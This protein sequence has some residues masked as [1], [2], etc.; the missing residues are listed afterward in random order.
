MYCDVAMCICTHTHTHT[1]THNGQPVIH[2]STS[3]LC[4]CNLIYFLIVH[5]HSNLTLACCSLHLN[6][7]FYWS[8]CISKL[9]SVSM[10]TF[11]LAHTYTP[12]TSTSIHLQLQ[13]Q[14]YC[15]GK[16]VFLCSGNFIT[17]YQQVSCCLLHF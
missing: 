12:H 9:S 11:M 15:L 17:N 4:Y 8:L 7:Y 10:C 5:P 2:T 3:M 16:F 14:V 13:S 1:H 6:L